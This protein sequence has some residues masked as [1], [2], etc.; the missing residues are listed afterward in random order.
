MN[1]TFSRIV[2][3]CMGW[4]AWGARLSEKEMAH[5]IV[6]GV[7]MGITTFDHADIYGDYTTEA[8]FGKAFRA[9]GLKRDDIQLVTK[10]GIQYVGKTRKNSIKHYQYDANYIIWSAERSLRDLG[11][12]YV[13]L[14]L[15]HRPSP[16]IEAQEVAKAVTKLKEDGK[17]LGFGVS[18][19]TPWQTDLIRQHVQVDANQIEFSLTHHEALWDGL[20]DHMQIKGIQPMAW[21]P[22][23]SFFGEDS[24]KQQRIA[25]CLAHLGKKY[26]VSH[27]QL[28]L[29]WILKHPAG[30]LPVIGTTSTDRMELAA[31]ATTFEMEDVDWF[32]LLVA[33]CGHKVP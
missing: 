5:R 32:E 29:S 24:P 8:E 16:L 2:Q 9:C 3:G 21:S 6:Q 20:L 11:V 18:N 25:N 10:C 22:L 4:G 14:F 23:G 27:D 15:L 12:S 28:L 26:G 19:F 33:S 31:N 13:D 7:A 30:I 17:I 1:N